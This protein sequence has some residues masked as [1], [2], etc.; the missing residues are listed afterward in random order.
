MKHTPEISFRTP[1]MVLERMSLPFSELELCQDNLVI[2]RVDD[3]VVSERE[4][5]EFFMK[6]IRKIGRGKPVRLLI[7]LGEQTSGDEESR[8]F[9]AQRI[10]GNFFLRV[11]KPPMPTKLF[12]SPH[13]AMNWLLCS[14]ATRLAE[15]N[16]I[17]DSQRR[18]V[19]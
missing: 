16:F 9:L 6:A 2:V 8:N 3:T 15:K 7:I 5:A 1:F 19:A 17:E 11:N 13:E 14:H 18:I 12:T 10:I 4:D